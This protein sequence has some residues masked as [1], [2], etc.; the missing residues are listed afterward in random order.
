MFTGHLRRGKPPCLARNIQRSEMCVFLAAGL[1]FVVL[2]SG[3]ESGGMSE[4][5]ASESIDSKSYIS[6]GGKSCE[7]HEGC[8]TGVCKYGVCSQPFVSVWDTKKDGASEDDQIRLPLVSTGNYDFTVEWGD[9]TSDQITSYD[10]DEVLHTYPEPGEYTVLI[11]GILEGWSFRGEEISEW[12][13]D[14]GMRMTG[15]GDEVWLQ[16]YI[17]RYYPETDAAKIVEIKEWGVLRSGNEDGFFYGA[18]NLT[19]TAEDLLYME[20][21]TNMER[22]FD[23]CTSIDIVPS[24]NEW[25]MS[26]VK[27]MSRMFYGA[28]SFDQDIGNWD[29]GSVEYMRSMFQGAS[30]FD[31]DIGGWSVSSVEWMGGMFMGASSFNQDIGGWDVSSVR[32]TNNMFREA[33]SFNQDIGGWNTSNIR[34]M[35]QMFEDAVNFDQDIGRWAVENVRSMRQMFMGAQQFN[36]DISEWNTASVEEMPRMFKNAKRFDQNLGD[37]DISSVHRHTPRVRHSMTEMFMGARLSTENYDA[38]LN[39]WAAQDVNERLTFHGGNSEYSPQADD[40]RQKLVEEFGW[41]INDGGRA[42]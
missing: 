1:F 41:T 38:I 32:V 9:G 15:C 14:P 34:R 6:G 30:S 8:D 37:W 27:N 18:S 29:V 17:D 22:A 19:I 20:D 23:G 25:D 12:V 2:L 40:A 7:Q 21:V 39:G 31:Q 3:A 28:T 11:T 16:G 26:A 5:M 4:G 10:Q 24:M 36:Q 35:E 33:A 13:E 42:E